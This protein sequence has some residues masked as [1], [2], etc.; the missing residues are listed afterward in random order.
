MKVQD[1]YAEDRFPAL[2]LLRW[3]LVVLGSASSLVTAVGILRNVGNAPFM[4]LLPYV[5]VFI[6]GLGMIVAAEV[7]KL[8]IDI[9]ENGRL[10]NHYLRYLCED[11]EEQATRRTDGAQ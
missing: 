11:R 3:T 6:C 4:M 2:R 7:I 10:T 5:L 9:E 8:Q 1:I